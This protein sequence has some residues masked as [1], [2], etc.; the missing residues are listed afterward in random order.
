MHCRRHYSRHFIIPMSQNIQPVTLY[1]SSDGHKLSETGGE[2]CRTDNLFYRKSVTNHELSTSRISTIKRKIILYIIRTVT[3][4]LQTQFCLYFIWEFFHL[5]WSE[6]EQLLRY[7]MSLLSSAFVSSLY[8]FLWTLLSRDVSWWKQ[9][10]NL[11]INGKA[12]G[13]MRSSNFVVWRIII[14]ILQNMMLWQN[15]LV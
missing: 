5:I 11:H 6:Y 9:W 12:T 15:V 2:L 8:V 14:S 1:I 13:H 10:R 4:A 7:I 3:T